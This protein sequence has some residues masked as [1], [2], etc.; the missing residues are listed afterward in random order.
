MA[1]A[2]Y[3]GILRDYIRTRSLQS[4]HRRRRLY[5]CRGSHRVQVKLHA[6]LRFVFAPRSSP[7]AKDSRPGFSRLCA[8]LMACSKVHAPIANTGLGCGCCDDPILAKEGQGSSHACVANVT[9]PNGISKELYSQ[10]N[11]MVKEKALT[12]T[13]PSTRA[14]KDSRTKPKEVMS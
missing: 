13:M 6:C 11:V 4:L 9:H 8:R 10:R 14:S 3:E 7:D 1:L 12:R 5:S 2:P